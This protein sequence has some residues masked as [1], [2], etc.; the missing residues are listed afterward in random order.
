MPF[1]IVYQKELILKRT[2]ISKVNQIT[3]SLEKQNS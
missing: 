1:L 2:K 3:E